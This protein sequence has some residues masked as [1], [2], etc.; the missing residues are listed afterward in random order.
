MQT[1]AITIYVLFD[2]DY[3]YYSIDED[4]T[5]DVRKIN[6]FEDIEDVVDAYDML[7]DDYEN[8]TIRE[9]SVKDSY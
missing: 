1:P 7:S 2:S 3:G 5:W 6:K 9:L 4:W 8:I